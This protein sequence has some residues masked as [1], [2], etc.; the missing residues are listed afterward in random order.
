VWAAKQVHAPATITTAIFCRHNIR[1]VNLTCGFC[2]HL[3]VKQGASSF[4][5]WDSG[6]SDD[7]GG[8]DGYYD[9]DDDE[10][11]WS[12]ILVGAGVLLS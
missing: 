11:G 7:L 12:D 8:N 1:N 9:D 4:D 10:D 2:R 3:F 5:G 6:Y